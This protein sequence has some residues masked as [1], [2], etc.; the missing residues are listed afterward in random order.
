M[1]NKV[2]IYKRHLL[3]VTILSFVFLGLVLISCSNEVKDE[4]DG[5]IEHFTLIQVDDTYCVTSYSGHNSKV[6]I[7][8]YYNDKPITHIGSYAF[9]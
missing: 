4:Y 1:Q 8:L 3:I 2:V 6:S 5:N 7:P 9:F